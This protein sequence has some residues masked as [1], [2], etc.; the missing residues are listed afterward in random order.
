MLRITAGA[1]WDRANE[2]F[3][4]DG[5]LRPLGAAS[6]VSS[7]DGR[8]DARLGAA[9][10]L[11]STLSG[12]TGFDASLGALSIARRDASVDA[13]LGLEFGVMSRLT[14]G[15]RLRAASHAIEPAV[16]HQSGAHRGHHGVQP[17]MD[18]HRGAR[19]QN[20]LLVAQFDSAAAQTTRRIAQC[21][22]LP[23]T[24]GCGSLLAGLPA[25]QALVGQCR[26]ICR[27]AEPAVR[28][29]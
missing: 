29:A 20:A 14:V 16:T 22:A 21:Q 13:P 15:V 8:Y 25:A 3:D 26:R 12:L 5:K 17:R 19:S 10:P 18:Q 28:R 27:R 4:A 11:V 6:S 23:A 2:R 7:W 9:N 1:L 24:S